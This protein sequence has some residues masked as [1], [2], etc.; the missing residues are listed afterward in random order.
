MHYACSMMLYDLFV[1]LCCNGH[2]YSW[3]EFDL[4]ENLFPSSLDK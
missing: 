3:K 2:V 4:L 1:K